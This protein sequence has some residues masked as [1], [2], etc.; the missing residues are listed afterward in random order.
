VAAALTDETFQ[1][2][3]RNEG[4]DMPPPDQRTPEALG[5][6]QKAEIAKWWPIVKAANIKAE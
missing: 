2:R 5:A 4:F 1:E 6:Y 3:L